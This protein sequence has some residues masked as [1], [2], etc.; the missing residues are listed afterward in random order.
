[1]LETNPMPQEKLDAEDM[2]QENDPDT[3]RLCRLMG[4]DDST[5][6]VGWLRYHLLVHCFLIYIA[7]LRV[8]LYVLAAGLHSGRSSDPRIPGRTKKTTARL[9]ERMNGCQAGDEDLCVRVLPICKKNEVDDRTP[10]FHE[11]PASG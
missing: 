8:L 5:E 3:E 11:E 10:V 9:A 4:I 1:M 7:L 6:R 2:L